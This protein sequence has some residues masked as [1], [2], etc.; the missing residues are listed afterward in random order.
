M[1]NLF[2]LKNSTNGSEYKLYHA[3]KE[4]GKSWT[5]TQQV[6]PSTLV[7]GVELHPYKAC[8]IPNTK[9]I[10]YSYIDHKKRYRLVMINDNEVL[11]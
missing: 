7:E 8:F 3:E 1:E 6:K 5:I 4:I 2:L 10:F 11:A 9:K